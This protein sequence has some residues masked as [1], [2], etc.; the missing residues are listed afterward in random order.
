MPLL[1]PDDSRRAAELV[2]ARSKTDETEVTVRSE[3][4]RFARYAGDGPTQSADRERAVVSIRV[5]NSVDDGAGWREARA[6][7]GGTSESELFAALDRATELVG[8]APANPDAVPLGGEAAVR[9]SELDADTAAH[10]FDEKARW[11]DAAVARSRAEGFDP[12]GMAHTTSVA[13]GV[14]NSAGRAVHGA[15]QRAAFS[16]TAT[17]PTGSGL[18]ERIHRRAGDVDAEAVVERALA[19]ARLAQEP[20]AIDPGEMTVVLEPNAVSSLLLFAG[21]HGFG[22]REVVEESSFLCGRVGAR[23]FAPDL[24]I[25]DDA[26]N[27]VYPGLPFDG[28]GTPKERVVL[29]DSGVLKGP[30]TDPVYARKL[31]LPCTGHAR[32]QPSSGGPAAQNLVVSPGRASSAE[33]LAGVERGLL[34]TQFHYTNVIDPRELVLTGMTRNGTFLIENGEVTRAVKNLRFTESLVRALSR[35]TGI[36]A[37]REVAGALFDGEIVAP[38]LR[39]DGFRFTSSTDF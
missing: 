10:A 29:V 30:V 21:Y 33:L 8:R 3:H 20:R 18:G 13:C 26:G 7:V 35:V 12:A 38:A 32:P 36:G 14:Y 27:D 28:E 4:D 24:S 17:G 5:R 1:G 16:L 23:A 9:A 37:Q 19:K 34:I 22:A 39:I 31:G 11:I 2:L 15:F 6:T 25:A